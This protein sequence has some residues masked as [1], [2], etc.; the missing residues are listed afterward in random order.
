MTRRENTYRLT[1]DGAY[2]YVSSDGHRGAPIRSVALAIDASIG[3][4]MR[5]G[6]GSMVSRWAEVARQKLSER[7][8]EH[9]ALAAEAARILNISV[10]DLASTRDEMARSI[11][12]IQGR[13]CVASLNHLLS[14]TGSGK[15]FL[16]RVQNGAM[17]IELDHAWIPAAY[18]AKFHNAIKVESERVL[19]SDGQDLQNQAAMFLE[20]NA[21]LLQD[22]AACSHDAEDVAH[23]LV[24]VLALGVDPN[25]ALLKEQTGVEISDLYRRS[26]DA[27]KHGALPRNKSKPRG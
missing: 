17:P 24:C 11:V 16:E 6:E 20:G 14:H 15:A 18:A 22:L 26:I 12:V 4:V 27:A 25:W 3:S 21:D 23:D 10:E 19:P 8:P 13:F 7:V 9:H 1:S 2:V 5:H